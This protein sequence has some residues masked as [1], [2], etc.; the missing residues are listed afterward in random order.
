MANTQ[1]N[2]PQKDQNQEQTKRVPDQEQPG[3]R[4]RRPDVEADDQ[5][6]TD[7]NQ[8]TGR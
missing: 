4:E 5:P 1:Q 7:T 8:R 3:K 2:Q 6:G